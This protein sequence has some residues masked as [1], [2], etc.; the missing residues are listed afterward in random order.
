MASSMDGRN[1]RAGGGRP[2]EGSIKVAGSPQTSPEAIRQILSGIK[3]PPAEMPSSQW[4]PRPGTAIRQDE[5]SLPS[6]HDLLA[7]VVVRAEEARLPFTLVLARPG[8]AAVRGQGSPAADVADVED[9]GAALSAAL[10]PENDLM[11]AG[12]EHF[13]LVL[14]GRGGAAQREALRLMR[15]AAAEGAPLF[16]WAAARFPRDATTA[17]GLLAVATARLD[18]TRAE[19]GVTPIEAASLGRR[20]GPAIWTGVAAAALVGVAAFV[21][22]GSGPG[23]HSANGVIGSGSGAPAANGSTEVTSALGGSSVSGGA[24]G[25]S[26]GAAP[27]ASGN[28]QT[29]RSA[30]GSGAGAA[31]GGAAGGSKGSGSS[32][33]SGGSSS[34]LGNTGATTQQSGSG[35]LSTTSSIPVVG[36]LLG[37]TSGVTQ[38]LGNTGGT[39]T[40]GG[41]GTQSTTTTSTTTT[42]LV[43]G[44][45]SS[46]S[47]TNSCSGL[48]KTVTC[49]VNGLLGGL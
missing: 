41:L 15:R 46:S 19:R 1:V 4:A 6:A 22:H 21:L 29:G 14:P 33:G 20:S 17:A 38:T 5:L 42:T 40:G 34:L 39:L 48:L 31:V 47:G 44:V 28:V 8:P 36:G 2:S 49:T 26:G 3:L 43:S 30:G 16:T 25:S 45:N 37:G 9:L 13:A 18:G 24:S 35:I 23:V 32:T 7:D 10:G 11:R 27:S 12:V